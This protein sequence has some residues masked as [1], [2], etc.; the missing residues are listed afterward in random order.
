M[1]TI[2]YCLLIYSTVSNDFVNGREG[3]D[4]RAYVKVYLHNSSSHGAFFNPKVLVFFLFLHEIIC[5][6]AHWKRLA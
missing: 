5:Y 1:R 3:P 2:N 6:G 4:K